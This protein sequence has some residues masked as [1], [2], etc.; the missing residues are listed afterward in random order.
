MKRVFTIACILAIPFVGTAQL[1]NVFKKV[2]NKVDQRLNN[3]VDK[4][5]DQGLDQVEG[6]NN[7]GSGKDT[8]TAATAPKKEESPGV[9]YSKY[10][11]VPGEQVLYFE[12]FDQ[13]AIAE[14]P[15][16]WNTNGTGEVNSIDKYPGKWLR[17]HN[18]FAYLSANQKDFGENYTVEFDLILQLKNNGWM[19]P[20]FDITFLSGNGEP[21]TGNNF[22]EEYKKY[23]AITASF[24][25]GEYQS[26]KA[27]LDAFLEKGDYFK[28]E[29]KPFGNLE[30]WYGT[31]IH[32]AVQVQKERFRMWVNEEKLYDVPKGIPANYVMNQILFKV[33]S[34][35]YNENQYGVFIGNIK[36]ATG[37]PDTRHKLIEEGKFSTTGI[38]FDVN[39][40]TIKPES[41][42]V[43][44]EIAG[45]LRENKD[46]KI[47]IVGHTDSDGSDA[48]NLSLSQKRS[49]AVKDALVNDFGI[50]ADR[51]DTDGKGESLPVGD[52]RTK[53]G[54][55]QNRR[56]EFIKR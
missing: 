8:A 1:G 24:Y 30:K 16:G 40:A 17:L 2:K 19:Y 54:K 3:K 47:S 43:L 33:G 51:I 5:I 44:K 6:K 28:G 37:K 53:E 25:P 32:F 13:E 36:V 42:G 22:F 31:P 10:D 15:A 48:A 7:S 27:K 41:N 34:T 45:V 38:L 12:N 11:F 39:A 52:N 23:A 35:N 55:A 56:V 50:A 29:A 46:V 4:A 21:T 49:A 20:Q 9:A 18:P 26:S 14:L